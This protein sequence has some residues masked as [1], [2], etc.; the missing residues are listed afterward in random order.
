MA[1]STQASILTDTMLARFAERAAGYD[2]ENRF[3]AEDFEELQRRRLSHDA[4]CR[5]ELGGGGLTLAEVMREQRRLAYHAPATALGDQHARLLDRRGRRSV[6]RRRQVAGV[7]A[8]P[9]RSNGEV[10]AAGHAEKRQRH[11]GPCCRPRRPSGSMAATAS[12]G[13]KMFGSLTPVWTWLGLHAHGHERPGGSEGRA[14]LH[15]ARHRGLRDRGDMGHARHARHRQ[16][17]HDPRGRL[18]SGQVHRARRTR[19]GSR[20]PT[21]SSSRSSP[22][23]LTGFANMYSASRA[24]RSIWPSRVS[25]RRHRSALT[26]VD[27]VPP[28][29]PERHRARW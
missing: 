17:R 26:P 14:R 16:P 23:A 9:A 20:A 18:R 19:P 6:A 4:R 27:G 21:S 28:V 22:W 3:F 2:R 1:T 10:Y 15:A 29:G 12:A 5:R 11:S 13:H 7:V 24:T 25:R 8:R